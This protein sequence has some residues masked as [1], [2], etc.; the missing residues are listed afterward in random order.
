M[1]SQKNVGTCKYGFPFPTHSEAKTTYN[2][3]SRRWDY[4]KP[5][6]EDRNVVPYHASILFLWGAHMNIQRINT[7]YWS[8]YLLKYAMKCEPHG[9]IQLDKTNIE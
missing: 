8:Y 6:F 7:A 5:R 4:Y 9:P 3:E 1:S 2:T